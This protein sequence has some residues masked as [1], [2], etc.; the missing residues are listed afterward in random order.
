CDGLRCSKSSSNRARTFN[1]A[2]T[3]S[4]CETL[5]SLI[6]P[7]TWMHS[8]LS[9]QG[10]PCPCSR[11]RRRSGEINFCDRADSNCATTLDDSDESN[12]PRVLVRRWSRSSF[13]I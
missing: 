1:L 11:R 12:N 7:Y 4:S 2:P 8:F 3:K 10:K 6:C 5:P 13:H 9:N